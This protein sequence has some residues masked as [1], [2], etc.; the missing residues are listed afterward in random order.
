M[1]LRDAVHKLLYCISDSK[2]D[3][4]TMCVDILGQKNLIDEMPRNS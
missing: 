4:E 3:F 1:Y 2:S